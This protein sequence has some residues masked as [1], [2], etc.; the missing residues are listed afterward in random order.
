MQANVTVP[1]RITE[2]GVVMNAPGYL[3]GI[4]VGTDGTNAVTLTLHDNATAGS[5]TKLT[6]AFVILGTV[7]AQMF[8]L[9]AVWCKA[10]IYATVSVAGGG[11]TE[12]IFYCKKR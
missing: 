1:V 4:L 5:G 9:P 6:P 12:I 10:G 2:T 3:H 7:G 8:N 11:T